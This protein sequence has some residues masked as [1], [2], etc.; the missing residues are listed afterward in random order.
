MM[1]PVLLA[2]LII[3]KFPAVTDSGWLELRYSFLGDEDISGNNQAGEAG[4]ELP[5]QLSVQVFQ[6]GLPVANVPVH[7]SILR[8]PE[9]NKY[10]GGGGCRLIDTLVPTDLLG[11]A[12]TRLI[13]GSNPGDYFIRAEAG[14]NELI[15][16]IKGLRRRW[17]VLTVLEIL[18]GL[19][20]FLF[21]LY[22]GSKGLRRLAG[23]RLRQVLFSL[24]R[25]RFLGFFVGIAV[26]AIFQSSNA[27]VSL[28]ISL[29]STGL[30]TLPQS[31]GVILGADVGTTLTVQLLS[32]HIYDYGLLAVVGGLILMNSAW[33]LRDIGQVIFGFGLVLF[34][35]KV[36]LGSVEPIRFVPQVQ[37]VLQA[38]SLNPLYSFIIAL[39][40]TA[41][42]R[43]SA[44]TIGM[45]V[46]LSFSGLIE[47]RS[48]VPFLLGANVG[49]GLSSLWLAWKS[50]AEGKRV[51]A[52]Q[53]FFKVATVLLA[54]PF[55]PL[56]VSLFSKT[57]PIVA[58]QLANAHTFINIVSAI[59]AL[60]FLNLL[61]KLLERFIP[62][63]SR[64]K[65]APRYINRA[66]LVSAE[67][68]L[69]QATRE[70]LRM[71]E[72]VQEMLESALTCFLESDKEGCRRLVAEDDQVDEL[73]VE[74]TWFLSKIS[75]ESL[76]SENFRR[77]RAL[78]Y[79]TDELEHI[80][81]IVSKNIVT[82]TRKKI[83]N[84]LA[85]SSAGLEEIKIFHQEIVANLSLSINCL[86]TWDT[87]MAQQ[88]AEK[89]A[90][91]VEK[92]QEL[93]N[94]H[95]ERLNLGLKETIDTSTIHLDLISD[96]ERINFHCSQ[97]GVAIAGNKLN[98]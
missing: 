60:P 96:L 46:G 61:G 69:A 87:K 49:S 57:S 55:V 66:A 85:F 11:F 97:I 71:G 19:A 32:F 56:I 25:N 21:G 51:A 78:F 48:A 89:R 77:I 4:K 63:R 37:R 92:K 47:L 6:Q 5:Q 50:N 12:R 52:A 17:Y 67:L 68:A 44:A 16:T 90:W 40:F 34:S 29:A 82:Y 3:S 13:L 94:H 20:I 70:V 28:L 27:A 54:L 33:R 76:S 36:V 84:N 59:V 98:G 22:Y 41:L 14:G 93:V 58:R 86:A 72:I 73:E 95:L 31:L 38:G 15:F 23:D 30:I 7:F 18:G 35:L 42:L 43:S 83:N 53:T 75:V 9:E 8:E 88:L 10:L 62:D 65:M 24:T 45:T 1:Y 79:I 74:I 64:G 26:S 91:G 39:I 2:V 80:A 81:D